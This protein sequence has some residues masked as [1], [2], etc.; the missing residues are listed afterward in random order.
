M[1]TCAQ[2]YDWLGG[3]NAQILNDCTEVWLFIFLVFVSLF[4]QVGRNQVWIWNTQASREALN[5]K[6]G[7]PER[8][9]LVAK[10]MW[11]TLLSF[12]LYIINFLLIVGGNVWFLAAILAGNLFGTWWGMRNQS[13]DK[14]KIDTTGELEGMLQL[15][16]REQATLNSREKN[17]LE[18]FRSKLRNFL[19]LDIADET[20]VRTFKNFKY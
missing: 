16:S 1:S 5:T 8:S 6:I 7:S 17:D 2:D 12:V 3:L 19:G 4:I 10:L 15:L 20:Q 13:A 14:H 18:L 11:Y 9:N